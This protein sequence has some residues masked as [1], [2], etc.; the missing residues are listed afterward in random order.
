MDSNSEL[1]SH[2]L[3]GYPPRRIGEITSDVIF[4]LANIFSEAYSI[5]KIDK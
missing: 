2:V 3:P 5:L 4:K 1:K